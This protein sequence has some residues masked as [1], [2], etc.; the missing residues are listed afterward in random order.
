M[1]VV[2]FAATLL[3]PLLV[4]VVRPN[5]ITIFGQQMQVDATRPVMLG[6]GLVAALFGVVAYRQMGDRSTEPIMSNLLAVLRGQPRRVKG[7]LI[8]VEGD[9]RQDTGTQSRMLTDWLRATGYPAQLASDPALDESLLASVLAGVKLSGARAHAL[10]AAAVRADVVER[11]V[12]PA[13][14]AGDLV[15]MERYVDSPLAQMGAIG[16]LDPSD[17]EGLAEWATGR[18]RPDV[19]VLL[20][21]DPSAL[22]QPGPNG[23]APGIN[24]MEHHWR[25]QRLLTEMAAADPDRYVVVD[26]D[27]PADEVAAR[28]RAAVLP[29]LGNRKLDPSRNG[30][31]VPTAGA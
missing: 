2:L 29:A 13:L 9:T 20:D 5:N 12:L 7:M 31:R 21:R 26:A 28:V 24:S 1:K 16:E 4:G 18:L 23:S 11:T 8:A 27:G 25:V 14:D 17:L 6:A 15:V 3:V 30:A 19:T 10:V 22:L